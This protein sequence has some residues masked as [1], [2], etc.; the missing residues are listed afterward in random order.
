M[1]IS[2]ATSASTVAA[3]GIIAASA[4]EGGGGSVGGA[5]AAKLR[6]SRS[7]EGVRATGGAEGG[8]G[9]MGAEGERGEGAGTVR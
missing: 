9:G 5:L 6:E 8:G 2:F 4:H 7:R 3:L 1:A